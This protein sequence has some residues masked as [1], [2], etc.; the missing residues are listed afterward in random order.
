M[1][2]TKNDAASPWHRLLQLGGLAL[3]APVSAPLVDRRARI[4]GGQA[5]VVTFT[6][7]EFLSQSARY[8]GQTRARDRRDV[9]P[10]GPNGG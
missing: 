7:G 10:G 4:R 6:I 3:A 1:T 2:T 5:A 8:S 9:H